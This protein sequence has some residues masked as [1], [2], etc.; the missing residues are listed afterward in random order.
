MSAT[1]LGV[2]D[3]I[4]GTAATYIGPLERQHMTS[5]AFRAA[6]DN[7]RVTA[8]HWHIAAANGLGGA[9]TAWTG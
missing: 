1:E 5:S 6:S 2:G 7:T 4:V 8:T 9:L 3:P